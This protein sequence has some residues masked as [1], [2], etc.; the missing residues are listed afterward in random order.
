MLCG[1][2]N[3]REKILPEHLLTFL[4]LEVLKL[5]HHPEQVQ[6]LDYYYH[7]QSY[8]QLNLIQQLYQPLPSPSYFQLSSP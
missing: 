3:N 2:E 6:Y 5:Q 8:S 7:F 1:V 4:L